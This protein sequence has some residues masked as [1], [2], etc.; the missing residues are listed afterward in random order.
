MA[1]S[2]VS[3]VLDAP[4]SRS[5]IVSGGAQQIEQKT[6][7]ML[8]DSLK[9]LSRWLRILS[10]V[11]LAP[12][13]VNAAR[14]FDRACQ[15]TGLSSSELCRRLGSRLAKKTRLSRQTLA[16]WRRGRQ[17]VPFAAFL[18]VADLARLRPPAIFALSAEEF[19]EAAIP[20]VFRGAETEVGDE[21][22]PKAG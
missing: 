18:A 9:I 3:F 14:A 15:L 21:T 1:T 5:T 22:R 20:A 11:A 7:S 10:T 16:A 8:G 19:D 17:P 6:R 12:Y 2:R 13:A 4:W